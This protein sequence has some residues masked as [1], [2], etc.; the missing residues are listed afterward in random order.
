VKGE[1]EEIN[2]CI[3]ME[4]IM[5]CNTANIYQQSQCNIP[6]DRTLHGNICENPDLTIRG[7]FHTDGDFLPQFCGTEY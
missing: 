2:G 1:S 3:V 6:E 5:L 7:I 4:V